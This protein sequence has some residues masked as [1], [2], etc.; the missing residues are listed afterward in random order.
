MRQSIRLGRVFGIEIGLHPSWFVIFA[1]VTYSM[2]VGELPRAFPGWD[3][4]MYWAIGAVISILFFASVLLHELS[5]SLVARRFGLRV[6]DITLF[7]FGG[8]TALEDEA[9]RPRDEALMAAAGPLT[10]LALGAALWGI[11]VLVANQYVAAI[12]GWLG[13]INI[14]LG[15]FNLIPG[16]PMDGGRILRALIWKLRGDRYAATRNAAAVGRA[17]GYLLIAGGVFMLFNGSDLFGGIWLALIGWFLSNAAEATTAQVG[18][19]RSLTGIKV[20]SVMEPDPPS[21][22]P[23][24]TVATLVNERLMRGES[25][26]FLV[27]HDDGGLNGIVTLSDV[28]RVPREHWE[29][30]RVVDIMTRY[31]DL[32]TIGPDEEVME[33]LQRLQEREV[34]QLPVVTDG[35]RTVIGLLTRAGILRLIEART[36]LGV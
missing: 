27:R 22:S 21:V 17:F 5:H 36:R 11:D 18:V 33:G 6:R 3:Q 1:I 23:N 7:I 24:E 2:A 25:R 10:S 12:V 29:G 13:F 19:E 9:K 32:A 35:G 16:F 34:N 31:D 8:A 15:I 14:T 20:L 28:R 4:V 30:A 26:S